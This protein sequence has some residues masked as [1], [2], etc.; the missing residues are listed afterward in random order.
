M[1]NYIFQSPIG[2]LEI[3]E[4]NGS[5]IK[6][7]LKQDGINAVPSKDY[8]KHSDILYEAYTQLNEYFTGKRSVFDLP[9]SLNGTL[10]QKKVWKELQNIPYG[11]TRSYESIA[12]GIGNKKAVRAV[13]HANGKNPILIIVPC[14]R[15]INK[16]G[17]LGGFACGIEVKKFLLELETRF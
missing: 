9:I 1:D 16:N 3:C 6:V 13:G 15:V 11:E 17:K 14:H 7:S 10:F 8:T 12:C 4:E 5:I 2:L